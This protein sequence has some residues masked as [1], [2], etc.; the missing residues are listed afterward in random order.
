M[1]SVAYCWLQQSWSGA[2]SLH[3]LPS[4]ALRRACCSGEPY[5]WYLTHLA[6]VCR[7]VGDTRVSSGFRGAL[8]TRSLYRRGS[9][10]MQAQRL[11]PA[12]QPVGWQA[13]SRPRVV[14]PMAQLGSQPPASSG[15]AS[16]PSSRLILNAGSPPSGPASTSGRQPA[17][18]PAGAAA[19][20][21]SS[22]LQAAAV[23][24]PI[25]APAAEASTSFASVPRDD[26]GSPILYLGSQRVHSLTDRGRE[27]ITSMRGWAG[28]T[29]PRYLKETDVNWQPS[30][31]LPDPAADTFFDEVGV[32]D[33]SA[34]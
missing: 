22:A 25:A 11:P 5:A 32:G 7:L 28:E 21:R 16:A 29:L 14:M 20:N 17:S 8:H 6:V 15:S 10:A 18:M 26:K 34:S 24:A 12:G 27:V 4:P 2:C 13:H 23:A 19:S 31:L 30:D 33:A 3:S 9:A 1:R